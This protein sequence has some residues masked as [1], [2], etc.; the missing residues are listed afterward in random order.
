MKHRLCRLC[1]SVGRQADVCSGC[2]SR[3]PQVPS[4]GRA[5]LTAL[6]I[7]SPLQ[8]ATA[9]E[10][11]PVEIVQSVPRPYEVVDGAGIVFSLRLSRPIDHGRSRVFLKGREGIHELEPRLD[12][13][14]QYLF[15]RAGHLA[16]GPYELIWQVRSGHGRLVSKTVPFSV[17]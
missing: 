7:L 14:P 11:E 12:S 6:A 8:S 10:S 16:P 2:V 4:L 5:V 9:F 15:F 3:S 13:A 17:K 1:P